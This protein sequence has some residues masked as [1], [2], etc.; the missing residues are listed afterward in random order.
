MDS[1]EVDQAIA[2]V[3]KWLQ[4]NS[5]VSPELYRQWAIV[6]DAADRYAGLID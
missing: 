1:N 3:E 5:E 4:F 6:A 2:A